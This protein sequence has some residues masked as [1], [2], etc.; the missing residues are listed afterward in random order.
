MRAGTYLPS[1]RTGNLDNCDAQEG[2]V[3]NLSSPL[4]DFL[5]KV[6]QNSQLPGATGFEVSSYH[7]H[8]S[9]RLMSS[10]RLDPTV[11]A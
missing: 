9:I 7:A 10:T 1:E 2:Y 11:R 8:D 3:E 6:D 4:T 5:E